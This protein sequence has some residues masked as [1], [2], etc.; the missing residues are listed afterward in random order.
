[1][2]K[3]T[4]YTLLAVALLLCALAVALYLRIQAPPEAARLLP[5]S[6]AIVYINLKPLRAATHFDRNPVTPSPSLQ[7]FIDATGIVPERDLDAAAFALHGMADPAGPNGPVAFSEVFEGRFDHDRLARYL[8]ALAARQPNGAPAPNGGQEQYAGHTIYAIPSQGRTLRVCLLSYDV[9]AASN[10]PTPE[11]I[12]SILE[13]H[14]AAASPF[15]GSSLLEAR[16]K[17]VPAFASAWAVGHIALPFTDHGKVTL[18]GL[19]LPL[20]ADTTFVA[21]LRYAPSVKLHPAGV[22]LR[23]DQI[24]PTATEAER[25]AQS[26]N[27]LLNLFRN[28]QLVQQPTPR[29]PEDAALRQFT[30]SIQIE[31]NKDRVTLTA[32][33]PPD[34]LKHLTPP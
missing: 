3:R 5:E 31:P 13:R 26:L 25:S 16:Y 21:S 17:D 33:I 11:Q 6:D 12:H 27:Q 1:M 14:R 18:L 22:A 10:M 24:T 15:A 7:Q 23:I 2:R 8:A 28:I 29:T 34:T 4:R 20:P 9:V 30:D 32:T 19:E